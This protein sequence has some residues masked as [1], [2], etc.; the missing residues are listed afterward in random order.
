MSLT[1]GIKKGWL[2]V[3]DP[4]PDMWGDF[5]YW[6][7]FNVDRRERIPYKTIHSMSFLVLRPRKYKKGDTPSFDYNKPGPL[8]ESLHEGLL[9]L[10]RT[11]G[12]EVM[13][14]VL[15]SSGNLEYH[16]TVS[17][18]QKMDDE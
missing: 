16:F 18:S 13:K 17:A 3:F 15:V 1:W 14:V 2:F 12:K 11:D 7:Y 4:G 5:E 8:H 9:T 10:E 6:D